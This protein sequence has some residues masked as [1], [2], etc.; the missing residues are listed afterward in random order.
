MPDQNTT[1][2][3]NIDKTYSL[4]GSAAPRSVQAQSPVTLSDVTQKLMAS[5]NTILL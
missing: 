1:L 3:I 5:A 4:F 2:R